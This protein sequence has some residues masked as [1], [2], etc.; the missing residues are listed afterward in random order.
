MSNASDTFLTG[1]NIDFIEAQYARFLND[2]HSVDGSWQELFQSV[3][4]KGRPIRNGG[5]GHAVSSLAA[6]AVLSEGSSLQGKVD[7]TVFSFRLRGHL[8]A[9]LDPLGVPRPA[10]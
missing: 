9:E 4:K 5:N 7:Q 2:P 10:L 3:G 8:L 6:A 1:Q